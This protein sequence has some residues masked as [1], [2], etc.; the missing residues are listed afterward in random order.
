[1]KESA[2]SDFQKNKLLIKAVIVGMIV[3]VLM[4]P[5]TIV[6]G[7]IKEREQRQREAVMEVR[8]NWADTQIVTGPVLVV[9]SVFMM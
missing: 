7:T 1:M 5:A 4:I 2:V 6:Q 3:G 8:D 9:P